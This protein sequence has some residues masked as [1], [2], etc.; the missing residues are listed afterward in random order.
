MSKSEVSTPLKRHPLSV[1]IAML[2]V[3][4][5]AMGISPGALAQEQAE[6][7]ALLPGL[8]VTADWLDIWVRS[9]TRMFVPVCR[10]V[11]IF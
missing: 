11:R 7:A 6:A 2:P 3:S 8:N 9:S 4:L 10:E 5:L 1:A